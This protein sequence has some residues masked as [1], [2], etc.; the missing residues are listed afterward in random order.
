M[1]AVSRAPL[2]T[3]EAFKKRMGWSFKW[4]SSLDNEFNSDYHVSF[5]QD[6]IDALLNDAGGDVI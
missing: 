1:I 5:T 3:L 2:A 6:E 4:V